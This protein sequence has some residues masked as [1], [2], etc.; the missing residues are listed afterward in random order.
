LE[1]MRSREFPYP[2]SMPGLKACKAA[3]FMGGQ[4]AHWDM[5][6]RIQRAHA[7]EARNIADLEVLRQCALEV[8]LD[9]EE[10]ERLWSSQEVEQAVWAD[11]RSADL[12]GVRAVPTVI[13][14]NRWRLEGAVRIDVYRRIID[15][16]LAGQQPSG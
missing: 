12:L 13:F 4:Q 14:Q 8:G 2:Y 9:A 3:E 5:F 15:R 7:V 6:D 11:I 10:W 16:L 1:L